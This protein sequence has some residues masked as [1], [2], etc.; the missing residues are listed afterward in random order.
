MAFIGEN[1]R[2]RR[3]P[4][5]AALV[6][7]AALGTAS[8]S[9]APADGADTATTNRSVGKKINISGVFSNTSD[10]FWAT[11]LCGAKSRAKE[12]GVELKTYV[13]QGKDIPLQLKYIDQAVADN[14][15]GIIINRF[16]DTKDTAPLAK[17]LLEKGIP[18][19][20][21][22]E[23]TPSTEYQVVISN[24][25]GAVV[26]DRAMQEIGTTGKVYI[27]AGSAKTP[28]NMMPRVQPVID[29]IKAKSPGT[30]ILPIEFTNYEVETTR[31]MVTAAI[32]AH[33]DLS[34]VIASS[35]PEGEGAVAALR[36]TGM[37]GKIKLLAF[38]AVPAE[39]AALR[40]GTIFALG[41]QP[42]FQIGVAQLDAAADYVVA[43]PEGGPVVPAE[44][45]LFPMV[46]L[47]K[48]NIDD[49]RNAGNIYSST[50]NA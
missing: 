1:A 25:D 12:R 6:V 42:A 22:R 48:E 49:P 18:V 29:A 32:K 19:V 28:K 9:S 14:P 4:V 11:V 45:K 39:V 47:T 7:T 38:D 24:N 2:G 3:F 43:H 27:V 31:T 8:C 13:D 40:D 37:N 5:A 20:S 41:A 36:D 15:Q 17:K 23:F 50:C 26:V 16:G 35:G 46:M 21:K 44:K 30:V 10:A 34:M 33:P